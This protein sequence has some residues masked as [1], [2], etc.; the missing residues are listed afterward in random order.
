[1]GLRRWL[2]FRVEL[3]LGSWTVLL[4]RLLGLVVR[5]LAVMMLVVVSKP[6]EAGFRCALPD[7]RL[8]LLCGQLRCS[9]VI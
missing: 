8:V 3:V 9:W 6:S 1:M 4:G 2:R 5:H 7:V